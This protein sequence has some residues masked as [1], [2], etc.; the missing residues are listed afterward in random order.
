MEKDERFSG[1][2]T[3]PRF[4]SLPTRYRKVKIDDRFKGMFKDKKFKVKCTVDERSSIEIKTDHFTAL[5]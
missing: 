3:D 2:A 5:L 1:I 4:R